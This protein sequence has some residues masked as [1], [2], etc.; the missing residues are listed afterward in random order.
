MFMLLLL[1]S[2][3]TDTKVSQLVQDIKALDEE[4]IPVKKELVH[5]ITL[6]GMDSGLEDYTN[7]TQLTPGIAPTEA[8]LTFVGKQDPLGYR[9]VN[10]VAQD[11]IE[12][13]FEIVDGDSNKIKDKDKIAQDY[14]ERTNLRALSQEHIA[15]VRREGKSVIVDWERFALK[16]KTFKPVLPLE[17]F[18]IAHLEVIDSQTTGEP[19]TI[20][21]TKEFPS[22]SRTFAVPIE[23]CYYSEYDSSLIPVYFDISI[24]RNIAWSTGQ[25][26]FRYGQGFPVIKVPKDIPVDSESYQRV[27]NQFKRMHKILGMILEGDMDL[28]FKGAV[29]TALDPT[30]Y[31]KVIYERVAAGSGI[32]YSMLVGAPMGAKLSSETDQTDYWKLI[33]GEQSIRWKYFFQ[34]IMTKG[35]KLPPDEKAD[36]NVGFKHPQPSETDRLGQELLSEQVNQM[37]L[38]YMTVDEVRKLNKLPSMPEEEKE[39]LSDNP[40]EEEEEDEGKGTVKK[41]IETVTRRGK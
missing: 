29:G 15:N 41:I 32:P 33:K 3:A 18:D 4:E 20:K 40:D 6:L 35:A 11:V 19:E 17:V 38:S 34:D 7:L 8:Q 23:F 37:K 22:I 13:W 1:I 24:A 25:T 5:R 9:V 12:N 39:E 16:D 21:V 27:E 30:A 26:F 2:M 10:L 14:S 31:M 28:D 36:W